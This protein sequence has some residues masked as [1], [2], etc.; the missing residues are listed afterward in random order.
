LPTTE[1][2]LNLSN[3]QV[4]LLK[5]QL[6]DDYLISRSFITNFSQINLSEN[7]MIIIMKIAIE[8]AF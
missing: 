6:D 1:W 5:E 2:R 3:T 8:Y 4:D 7:M